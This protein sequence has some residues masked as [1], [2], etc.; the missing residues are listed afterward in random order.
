MKNRLVRE[1]GE[2]SPDSA[3]KDDPQQGFSTA[4]RWGRTVSQRTDRPAAGNGGGARV[5]R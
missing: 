4:K 2:E 5:K 1:G 3:G